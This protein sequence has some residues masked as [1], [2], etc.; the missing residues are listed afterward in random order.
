MWTPTL[1]QPLR[2]LAR[3]P[4]QSQ[5]GAQ[6]NAMVALTA[7]AQRHGENQEVEDFL[8][9]AQRGRTNPQAPTR[10]TAE[11]VSYPS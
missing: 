11:Q 4:V 6:R 9:D 5:L 1:W 2:D 8:A 3:W 7:I 10:D